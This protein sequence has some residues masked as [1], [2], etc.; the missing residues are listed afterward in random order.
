MEELSKKAGKQKE[1][2]QK[3]E[4]ESNSGGSSESTHKLAPA[5]EI[6]EYIYQDRKHS[7]GS[8]A[9]GYRDRHNEI[10]EKS[11]N[12][13][14]WK[15]IPLSCI[16]YFKKLPSAPGEGFEVVW[17]RKNEIDKIKWSGNS[18]KGGKSKSVD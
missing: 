5:N 9:I 11:V 16:E 3:H 17:H 2:S 14:T 7:I 1:N 10:Q 12:Y 8:Y 13:T 4:H 15:E 6:L 18:T